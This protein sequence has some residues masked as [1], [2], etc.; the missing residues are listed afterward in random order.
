MTFHNLQLHLACQYTKMCILNRQNQ[1]AEKIKGRKNKGPN[2]MG[3]KFEGPKNK[4]QN[5]K[6]A[7]NSKG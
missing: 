5:K 2:T 1:R 6:R 4:G 7:E 3:R